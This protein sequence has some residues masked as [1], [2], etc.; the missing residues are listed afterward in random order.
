M[1]RDLATR[2]AR[3]TFLATGDRSH[4]IHICHVDLAEAAIRG[5]LDEALEAPG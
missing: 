1:Q 2:S 5:V 3:G 4:N